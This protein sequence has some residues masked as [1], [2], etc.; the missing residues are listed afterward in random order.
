ME[1]DPER[2]ETG[3]RVAARLEAN[4]LVR[5]TA[6]EGLRLYHVPNF[7]SRTECKALIRMID[8][9]AKPSQVLARP[10]AIE[11]RTSTTCDLDRRHPDIHR[12]DARLADLL[13]LP[14]GLGETVQGQRYAPGQHFRQHCDWFR[15]NPGYWPQ[16]E[17][18][19]GQ[20]TWTAMIYLNDV[21]EGGE[22]LFPRAGVSFTP[23][24]GLLLAWNNM[25]ADGSPNEATLHAALPVVTGA[26][27]IITKWFREALWVQ[28]PV[29]TY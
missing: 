6:A 23:M 5:Q 19:G 18:Q 21:E 27:Y 11:V 29:R 28:R 26:K 2:A 8:A 17:A 25:A 22:T 10:E 13:G 7:L 24:R 3:R 14:F 4:P 1:P 9:D 20:R 15:D 16:M 12:L